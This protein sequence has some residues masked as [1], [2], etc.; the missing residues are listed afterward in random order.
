MLAPLARQL[1]LIGMY[2]EKPAKNFV[3]PNAPI[4]VLARI[5]VYW[6]KISSC[7]HLRFLPFRFAL[8]VRW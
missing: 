7:Q 8:C 5:V 6:Q 2:L 3:V 1:G 4:V